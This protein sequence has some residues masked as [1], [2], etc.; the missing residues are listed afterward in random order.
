MA[1]AAGDGAYVS[2]SKIPSR[3][4][5]GD[6]NAPC[7]VDRMLR[8]LASRGLLSC[9][10]RS[11]E[12]GSIQ[13]LYGLNPACNF[14]IRSDDGSSMAAHAKLFCKNTRVFIDFKNN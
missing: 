7:L 14:F 13:R 2:P 12:D 10:L 5:A 1:Q 8:L 3:L 4:P 6:P 9:S 11:L